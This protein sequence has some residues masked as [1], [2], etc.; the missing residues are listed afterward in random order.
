M[1]RTSKITNCSTHLNKG[2]ISEKHMFTGKSENM[3][4]GKSA[5]T[6]EK[7]FLEHHE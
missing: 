3:F 2:S 7:A 6:T 5:V 4:T 1:R